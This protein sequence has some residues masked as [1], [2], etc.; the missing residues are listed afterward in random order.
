MSCLHP[1]RLVTFKSALVLTLTHTQ[2][3]TT[4]TTANHLPQTDQHSH[5]NLIWKVFIF[6]FIIII[7]AAGHCYALSLSLSALP[8][9]WLWMESK[10]LS[11]AR[12]G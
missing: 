6:Q 1:L 2:Q 10:G 11:S 8:W 5:D 9:L 3:H 12:D 4:W 7:V